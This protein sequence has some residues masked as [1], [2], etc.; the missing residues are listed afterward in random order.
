MITVI[1]VY[2]AYSENFVTASVDSFGQSS[3]TSNK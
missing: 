3:F 2:L 1:Q